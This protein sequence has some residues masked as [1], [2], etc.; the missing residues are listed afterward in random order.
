MQSTVTVAKHIRRAAAALTFRHSLEP[1]GHS[2]V[3]Q[4]LLGS[5][6]NRVRDRAREDHAIRIEDWIVFRRLAKQWQSLQVELGVGHPP[7]RGAEQKVV[8][9][10][11]YTRARSHQLS[12]DGFPS[13][14]VA[15]AA[16]EPALK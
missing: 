16:E 13:M 14:Q 12:I 2:K 6:G 9:A 15:R 1:G 8:P 11:A 5:E 3:S 7:H 10:R 4:M